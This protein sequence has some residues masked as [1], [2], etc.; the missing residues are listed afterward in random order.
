MCACLPTAARC[1]GVSRCSQSAK[2]GSAPACNK[3]RTAPA[4]PCTAE[5]TRLT[6]QQRDCGAR[7]HHRVSAQCKLGPGGGCSPSVWRGEAPCR[8]ARCCTCQTS[9]RSRPA[10][11]QASVAVAPPSRTL[12]HRTTA[13]PATPRALPEPDNVIAAGVK[14][15]GQQKGAT[16]S[17]MHHPILAA[18]LIIAFLLGQVEGSLARHIL[19]RQGAPRLAQ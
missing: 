14:G 10:P 13:W 5:G 18:H 17:R 1:S 11:T 19:G 16:R 7:E 3:K 15:I 12:L 6:C 4:R 2:L 8:R 9:R